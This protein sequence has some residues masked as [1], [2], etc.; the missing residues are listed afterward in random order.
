[1]AV[2]RQVFLIDL[3]EFYTPWQRFLPLNKGTR[4]HVIREQLLSKH[5][6]IKENVVKT[7]AKNSQGSYVVDV[8]GL[9]PSPGRVPFEKQLRK[10]CVQRCTTVAEIASLLGPGVIV[11]C[12]NPYLQEW[13]MLFNKTPHT[14]SYS[15]R[16]EQRRPCVKP[17][18]IYALAH[19][20]VSEREAL[21]RL[22]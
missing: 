20:D 21:D 4:P 10:F 8:S 1:M 6:L 5:R 15:M 9:D 12:K 7:E 14:N 11:D 3:E 17:N 16:V 2:T 19:K 13:V 18:D 22:N